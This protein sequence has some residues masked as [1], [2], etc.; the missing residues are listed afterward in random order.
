[1][2]ANV[3]YT[4]ELRGLVEDDIKFPRKLKKVSVHYFHDAVHS[5]FPF[6]L[7]SLQ[8]YF[9]AHGVEFHYII[10]YEL[11]NECKCFMYPQARRIL[12]ALL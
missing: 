12:I 3:D 6:S 5:K 1:M 11:D 4:A 7:H 2:N 8:E 10:R 9:E